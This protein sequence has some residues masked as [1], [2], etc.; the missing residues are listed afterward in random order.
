MCLQMMDGSGYIECSMELLLDN[1]FGTAS[2]P[3]ATIGGGGSSLDHSDV[4]SPSIM[5]SSSF[6]WKRRI[7]QAISDLVQM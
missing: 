5:L 4:P 2:A 3:I 7:A 1:P 6:V